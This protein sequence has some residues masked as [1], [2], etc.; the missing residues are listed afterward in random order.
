[1]RRSLDILY[2]ELQLDV[3]I[4]RLTQFQLDAGE[5]QRVFSSLTEYSRCARYSDADTERVSL[6]RVSTGCQ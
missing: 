2:R 5:Y 3:N 1:M 6:I 4:G